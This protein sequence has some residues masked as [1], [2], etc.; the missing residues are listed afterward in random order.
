MQRD[1]TTDSLNQTVSRAPWFGLRT[2]YLECSK[3]SDLLN[4]SSSTCT[5]VS[6]VLQNKFLIHLEQ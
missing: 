1:E 3:A 5:R 2:L 6:N 4:N